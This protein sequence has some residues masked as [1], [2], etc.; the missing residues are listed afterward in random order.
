MNGTLA[1]RHVVMEQNQGP[2]RALI[3]V[4]SLE[5][6]NVSE[7]FMRQRVATRVNVQVCLF[8]Y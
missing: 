6:V 5:V 7:T 1:H 2:D 4:H 3:L 8:V